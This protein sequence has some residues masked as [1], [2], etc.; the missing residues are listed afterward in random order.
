MIPASSILLILSVAAGAERFTRRPSSLWVS[1]ALP[2]NS[3]RMRHPVLSEAF[4]FPRSSPKTPSLVG[5]DLRNTFYKPFRKRGSR[6]VIGAYPPG[7]SGRR[8]GSSWTR[9]RAVRAN[10]SPCLPWRRRAS[11]GGELPF[12]QMGT[13]RDG[14]RTRYV[15][16]FR[17]SLGGLAALRVAQRSVARTARPASFLAGGV[18]HFAGHLP[19]AVLGALANRRHRGGPD[20]G[21]RPADGRVLR[22]P[23]PRGEVR[24]DRADGGRGVDLGCGARRRQARRLQ[25]LT[26]RRA[27]P[28]IALGRG[29]VGAPGQAPGR[30]IP[31]RASHRLD[32]DLRNADPGAWAW[33]PGTVVGG[34]LIIGAGLVVSHRISA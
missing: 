27:G 25:Q 17:L 10:A 8:G 32:P 29:R 6:C 13:R 28:A 22:A 30:R 19:G 9:R 3:S 12:R 31:G 33:S 4:H 24:Q 23:L 18:P 16:T 11:C 7:R 14:S 1:L 34:A 21:L 2:C 26:G 15:P 5:I 20:R